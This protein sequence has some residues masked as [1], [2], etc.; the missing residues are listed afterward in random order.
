MLSDIFFHL[1]QILCLGRIITIRRVDT[2]RS[3]ADSSPCS[4]PWSCLVIP[5]IKT[6]AQLS[7]K[8]EF[9]QQNKS[10]LEK[11]KNMNVSSRNMKMMVWCVI[12]FIL[13]Y[14]SSYLLEQD[15][16]NFCL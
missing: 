11:V 14:F 8:S 4:Q 10:N 5:E 12:S 3:S 15:M 13:T 16:R 7:H 2:C 9:D 6:H 1:S